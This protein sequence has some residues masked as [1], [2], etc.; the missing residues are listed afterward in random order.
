LATFEY[1]WLFVVFIL[2]TVVGSFIN[3]VI[4][5]LPLERSLIWPGSRCGSCFQ[6]IRWYDNIP[7]LGYLWLRGRCRSCGQK[8]SMGYLGV[9]LFTGLCFAG[10]FY[11]EVIEDVHH[12]ISVPFFGWGAV[13]PWDH[14][15]VIGCQY[16]AVLLTFLIAASGCDLQGRE[17]PFPLTLTG[18]LIGLAGSAFMPWPWPNQLRLP[19]V[20]GGWNLAQPNLPEGIYAWPLWWPLPAWLPPGSW[21]EGLATGI[22]GMLMGTFLLRAIAFIFGIGMGKEGLGLGD[23]DL[24]MMAGSFLGWQMVMVAFF[25]SVVPGMIFGIFQVVVR[26]D[27]SLPFGP[28][29]A[30]GTMITCLCWSWIGPK[31]QIVFFWDTMMLILAGAS[32]VFLFGTSLL[33][34]ILNMLRK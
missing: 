5:R 18:T 23:A 13:F 9:E 17:I 22:A 3:V 27:N 33:L 21:Q 31:L 14:R 32:A 7:I 25:V 8:F 29:L 4:A 30:A 11:L 12:W 16:H 2:G 24:M 15:L 26:R 20:G 1:Y 28:S 6:P 10:L 19:P 34:R